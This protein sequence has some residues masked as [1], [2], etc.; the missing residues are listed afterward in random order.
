MPKFAYLSVDFANPTGETLSRAAREHVLDLASEMDI[1]VIEDAAYQAL[2]YDGAP[3]PPILALDVARSGSIEKTRTVYCGSFSKTLAPGLRVGWVCAAK[4]VVQKLVLIKQASDL[5]S[6]T[7]NQM[8]VA[9]VAE[10]VMESHV[11]RLRETYKARRDFM[12]DALARHMPKTVEWT[13]PAGGM[14]I[15]LTLPPHLDGA[16]LLA[17]SLETEKVAFVPGR[18]FFADGSGAN[19]LRLSYSCADEDRIEAGIGRLGRLIA[20]SS[21]GS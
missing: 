1:A 7:L 8:V 10:T 2:R 16:E 18:A 17:Q 20:R 14:F 21:A 3:I 4:P 9:Q 13:R 19:T 5:H 12:L 6:S 15:W 11:A